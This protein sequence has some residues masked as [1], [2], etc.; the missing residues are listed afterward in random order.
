MKTC[1]K[2]FLICVLLASCFTKKQNEF[3]IAKDEKLTF[4]FDFDATMYNF[5][6]D[7]AYFDQIYY[8]IVGGDEKKMAKYQ[9]F[10]SDL[11]KTQ[12][13][14]DVVKN[15]AAKYYKNVSKKDLNFA[16]GKIIKH[17]TPGLGNVIK[18]L[19][20]QGHQ[21]L[22]IG[23]SAF[24]CG[25][26]PDF[27][28]EFG[29]SKSDIYSGYFKDFSKQSLQTAFKFDTTNFEYVNCANPDSHT[30]YSKKKSDLIKLLK[31]EGKIKGKVVH[32]GDG[33]NDLEVWKAKEAD[34]FIGFGVNRYS[35]KVE[36]GSE[37]YVKTMDEFETEIKKI[38]HN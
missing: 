27:V 2:L 33:E 19:K 21:V 1:L 3:K 8:S 10:V 24:G 5:N 26:I 6:K 31:K 13:E 7:S 9:A 34:I 36:A 14:H 28:K 37:I 18:K 12:K 32:I 38:L 35:K 30:V 23:G 20:S 15:I 11:I 25:I 29:T 17:Q 16:I 22:I 4:I